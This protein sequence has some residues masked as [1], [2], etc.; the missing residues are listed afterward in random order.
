MWAQENQLSELPEELGD[1]T[2][3]SVLSI[4]EN[5]L[6]YLPYS[7]GQCTM[8][9]ELLI[10]NND[11][12]VPP[13]WIRAKGMQH[14]IKYLRKLFVAQREKVRVCHLACVY[15]RS[16]ATLTSW[17]LLY[18][19]WTFVDWEFRKYQ[20]SVWRWMALRIS[21]LQR[22][23]SS[24][25]RMRC[26]LLRQ[27]NTLHSWNALIRSPSAICLDHEDSMSAGVFLLRPVPLSRLGVAFRL[28]VEKWKDSMEKLT[29]NNNKLLRFPEVVR[30]WSN[31]REIQLTG[32]E[33]MDIP[34][35]IGELKD[36]TSLKIA[37]NKIRRLPLA[38]AQMPRLEEIDATGNPI[39]SP[40]PEVVARGAAA[41]KE[42][43]QK[44]IYA[45]KARILNFNELG[46]AE[47]PSEIWCAQ[48]LTCQLLPAC[49][50]ATCPLSDWV[51]HC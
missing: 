36:L 14:T 5:N 7:L 34:S 38:L 35:W 26:A 28:Q 1:C 32:N 22:T 49:A 39:T 4:S 11:L 43:L 42:Y 48:L 15:R 19:F 25:C 21:D 3:L 47:V 12:E 24:L 10:D 33:I 18:R 13:D 6:S 17:I 41:I 20:R 2:Q 9:R 37:D 30:Q 50:D 40:P 27:A 29:M 44:F 23:T 31:L 8:L 45:Q 46:I 16:F 51:C